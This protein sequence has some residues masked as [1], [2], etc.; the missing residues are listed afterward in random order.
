[1]ADGIGA[2]TKAGSAVGGGLLGA[3]KNLLKARE[4]RQRKLNRAV[5]TAWSPFT[6]FGVPSEK[7]GP[8]MLSDVLSGGLQG[9]QVASGVEN[10]R[11]KR[12][13]AKKIRGTKELEDENLKLRNK[14]MQSMMSPQQQTSPF[15][16]QYSLG[17]YQFSPFTSGV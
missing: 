16:S 14:Y 15:D 12:E 4:N 1:M 9:Y 8:D 2:L 13:L 17:D 5:Q 10:S 6:G 11:D 7:E 3:L